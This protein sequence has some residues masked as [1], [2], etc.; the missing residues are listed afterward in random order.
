MRAIRYV[1]LYVNQHP[2][3]SFLPSYV[4]MY[5]FFSDKN[6]SFVFENKFASMPILHNPKYLGSRS[7]KDSKSRQVK[8]AGLHILSTFLVSATSAAVIIH[9]HVQKRNF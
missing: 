9:L 7:F 2:L 8:F 3:N 6:C 4:S 1:N 5:S